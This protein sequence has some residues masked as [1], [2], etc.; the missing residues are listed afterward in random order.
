MKNKV[1]LGIGIYLVAVS[2]IAGGAV[3]FVQQTINSHG[4]TFENP[5]YLPTMVI[6]LAMLI[7]GISLIAYSIAKSRR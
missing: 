4:C 5:A 2:V 6:C 1:L 3:Y 7:A